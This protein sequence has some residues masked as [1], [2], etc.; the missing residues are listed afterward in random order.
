MRGGNGI[1]QRKT[2]EERTC[3]RAGRL[4]TGVGSRRLVPVAVFEAAVVSWPSG[5]ARARQLSAAAH[6]RRRST[7]KM[8]TT[9]GRLLSTRSQND[10]LGSAPQ[11]VCPPALTPAA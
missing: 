10:A 11:I 1:W 3:V 8:E 9:S 5:L 4:P 6:W 2:M 7:N